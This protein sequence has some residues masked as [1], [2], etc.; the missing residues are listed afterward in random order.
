MTVK[1]HQM[2]WR[3]MTYPEAGL[4]LFGLVDGAAAARTPL[5]GRGLDRGL[6]VGG[7]LVGH[8][9]TISVNRAASATGQEIGGGGSRGSHT[10]SG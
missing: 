1:A 7:R 5:A 3:V 9:L 10:G 2:L 6:D 4:L 8:H